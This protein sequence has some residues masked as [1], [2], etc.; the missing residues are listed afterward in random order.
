MKPHRAGNMIS[1]NSH[2]YLEA[3]RRGGREEGRAVLSWLKAEWIQ[4]SQTPEQKGQR[5][6]N[7]SVLHCSGGER[8]KEKDPESF[9][10]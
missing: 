6:R 3:W 10:S 8:E 5:G 1:S 9:T 7:K 2:Q 4:A